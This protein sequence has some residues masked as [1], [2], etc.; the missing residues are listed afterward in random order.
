[1]IA[2][3]VL[4]YNVIFPLFGLQMNRA[5]VEK[6]TQHPHWIQMLI[7]ARAA[8]GEEI[9]YRGYPLERIQQLTGSKWIAFAVSVAVFTFAHLAG[10]GAAQL[11]VVSFGAVILALLYLW[12]RDLLCNMVAHF[13]VDAVSFAAT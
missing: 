1:M 11:I 6:I 10:W 7:F 12:R 3:V 4:S 5:A 2:T 9:L 13:L 8:V